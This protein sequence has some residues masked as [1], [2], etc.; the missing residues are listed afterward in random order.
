MEQKLRFFSCLL[1][2]PGLQKLLRENQYQ[3]G[4]AAAGGCSPPLWSASPISLSRD[5]EGQ[6]RK[7]KVLH[8]EP[9]D[10]VAG[11]FTIK[12][13]QRLFQNWNLVGKQTS[14]SYKNSLRCCAHPS[15]V[16]C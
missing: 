2:G 4:T 13:S 9:Q 8:E 7:S 11:T 14:L 5:E 3:R 10:A 6:H 16:H 12:S 1:L 15:L